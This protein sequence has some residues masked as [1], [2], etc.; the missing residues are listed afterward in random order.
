MNPFV[1]C[2]D[3][4]RRIAALRELKQFRRAYQ[5]ALDRYLAGNRDEVFPYGTNKL[6]GYVHV[7]G[8]PAPT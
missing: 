8:P 7:A 4:A 5:E 2:K 1:A 6:R 3:K